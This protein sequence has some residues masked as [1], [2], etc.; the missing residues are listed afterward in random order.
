VRRKAVEDTLKTKNAM[1]SGLWSNPN[2]DDNKNT[3]KKA[4]L[5]IEK[6]YEDAINIIYN[7]TSEKEEYDQDFEDPF[8]SAMKLSD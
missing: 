2:F 4:L 8:F 6:S 3:R 7:N 1:I 5:D